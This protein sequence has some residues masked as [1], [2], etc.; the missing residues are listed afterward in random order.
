MKPSR[1]FSV[2]CVALKLQY[3]DPFFV[4]DTAP[5]VVILEDASRNLLGFLHFCRYRL[6]FTKPGCNLPINMH[7]L[8][9]TINCILGI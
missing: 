1:E 7:F 4:R 3:Q 2:G 6:T 5:M 9:A 8:K